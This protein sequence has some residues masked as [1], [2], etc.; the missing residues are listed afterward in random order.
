MGTFRVTVEIG[1]LEGRRYE[2]VEALVDTGATYTLLPREILD[3]LG[4][5]P[6][7]ERRFI[8]ADQREAVYP[9]AWVMARIDGDAQPTIAVFGE[10]G[11]EPLLGAVTLEEFGVAADPVGRRLVPVPGLLK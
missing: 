6:Q 9:T 3:R 2:R 11:C 1:D 4:V 7:R 10:S 8:L 5:R